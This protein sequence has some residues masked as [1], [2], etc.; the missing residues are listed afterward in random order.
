MLGLRRD[1]CASCGV[2][3]EQERKHG[4]PRRYCSDACKAAGKSP[5]EVVAVVPALPTI[6]E[7]PPVRADGRCAGPGCRKLRKVSEQARKYAGAQLD[8]DPFCSTTCCRKWHGCE[9]AVVG[10]EAQTEGDKTSA[11]QVRAQSGWDDLED[12]A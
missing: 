3:F 4:R 12:A 10:T 1:P 9:L 5:V 6:K 2:T 7:D 8:L 11:S